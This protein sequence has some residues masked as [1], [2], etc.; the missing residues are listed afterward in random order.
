MRRSA[1]DVALH[2]V[3][4]LFAL[5]AC[6][7]VHA[8]D[9][10]TKVHVGTDIELSLYT[11]TMFRVRVSQL[12]PQR[13]P[14][15]YEIPFIMGHLAPWP[16]VSVRTAS[17]GDEDLVETTA[18]RLRINRV[19]HLWRV[20]RL[21]GEPVYPSSGPIRGLF[22]DGYTV[23]DAA[24]AFLERNR[25]S[26]YEHWFYNPATQRYVDTYLKD[27]LIHDEFFIYGPDYPRLFQQMNELMGPE[28]LLPKKAYGFI[29]TQHL[30]CHGDETR[31]LDVARRLRAHHIPADT[32][33]IDY[34]W[35]DGC[36]GGDSDDSKW[37]GL[38]WSPAYRTPL[39]P[40]E[41]MDSLHAMHFD[42]MTIHHSAPDF[43]HRQEDTPKRPGDWTA[44]VYPEDDWWRHLQAQLAIGV[45]GTWQDTRQNDVTDGVIWDGLQHLLGDQRR[46]LFLGNRNVMELD[47]WEL[48]RDDTLPVTSLLGSRRYPF[49]WTGDLHTTWSELRFQIDAITNS[50]G[51]MKGVSYVTADAYAKNWIHQARW[52]QFLAFAPVARSHTMKPWDARLDIQSLRSIMA[53]KTEGL[54]DPQEIVTELDADAINAWAAKHAPAT[55]TAE[56]SVRKY[57]SLRYRLLPYLYST[58][59]VNY[60]TGLPI[61]R[62]MVLACPDDPHCASGR[63]PVQYL[64]GDALLVAPVY[65]D[66][67]SMEVYL[68][69]GDD[70]M[71]YTTHEVFHGGAQIDVDTRDPER[72]PLFVRMGSII[73]MRKPA[74]WIEATPDAAI[75]LDIY[76]GARPTT[77]PFHEDDGVTTAYQRGAVAT[78]ALST[79]LEGRDVHVRIGATVGTYTGIPDTR[80]WTLIVHDPIEG[81]PRVRADGTALTRVTDARGLEAVTNGWYPDRPHHTIIIKLTR[82]R[83]ADTAVNVHH[84]E[85]R[86]KRHS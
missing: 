3:L 43:P 79:Q 47:P 30:G 31:L 12:T 24:S 63:W 81:A 42:V 17:E 1:R 62:P 40:K 45:D 74:E 6:A 44:K 60:Q 27:D 41:L 23:F 9:Y 54:A 35:G 2:G 65:A 28:P 10:A 50:Q 67:A 34:E 76:P 36:P 64:L 25:N 26:R 80:V 39:S 33:V 4:V 32:L 8:A 58:A 19:T 16:A 22:R 66:L 20:E 13:F 49:R 5:I 86:G 38:D 75:D 84:D 69:A 78:T 85:T 77:T 11:P 71:D 68:P 53:F 18:L 14:N 72:L 15:A 52:N 46:V 29:Q 61:A 51:S 21:T 37:G 56:A 48:K 55:R 82:P 59:H 57:L 83:T 70:W 73:P 7:P